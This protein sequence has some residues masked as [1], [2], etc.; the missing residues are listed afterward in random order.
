MSGNTLGDILQKIGDHAGRSLGITRE[1]AIVLAEKPKELMVRGAVDQNFEVPIQSG[2][3]SVEASKYMFGVTI[4]GYFVL[5]SP[6]KGTWNIV[7]TVDD[8]TVVDKSG[9]KKGEEITF[10]AETSFW[11]DTEV[12]VIATWSIAEDTTATVLVHATY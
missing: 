11:G 8:K 2:K 1:K 10:T 4:T 9:V 3:G 5:E 7:A 6:N 12:K